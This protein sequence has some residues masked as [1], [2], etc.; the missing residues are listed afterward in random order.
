MKNNI[1]QIAKACC[2]AIVCSLVL[3]LIFTLIIQLFSLSSSV[4][5]PVNQVIKILSIAIGGIAFIREDKG[6]LKGVIYGVAAVILTYILFSIIAGEFTL[7]WKIILE[8]ILGA[9]AGGI[10]GVIAVNIKKQ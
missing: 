7:S 2:L 5:K 6:L 9:V 10:A 8:L 3:V 4:I 1:F